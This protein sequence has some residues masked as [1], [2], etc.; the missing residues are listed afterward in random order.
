MNVR[1]RLTATAIYT[2]GLGFYAKTL[3]IIIP[4]VAVRLFVRMSRERNDDIV[5]HLVGALRDSAPMMPVAALYLIAASLVAI[6]HGATG[7]DLTSVLA[8]IKFTLIGLQYGMISALAGF[9]IVEETPD[10]ITFFGALV[11]DAALGCAVFVAL[12]R[13]SAALWLW[14]GL[15][16]TLIAGIGLIGL[17]R[18]AVYGPWSAAS[19]RY[20]LD[21]GM[22]IL[23]FASLG[24]GR[25]YAGRD[26]LTSLTTE[27]AFLAVSVPAMMLALWTGM[28]YPAVWDTAG[29]RQFMDAFRTSYTRE[30]QKAA[31]I[32]GERIMPALMTPSWMIDY[33]DSAI[34][35]GC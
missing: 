1:R 34:S 24:L 33:T 15:A 35:R 14:S 13:N 25:A 22:M 2:I 21:G 26:V 6:K 8:A 4:F 20:T 5:P 3:I 32:L 7:L 29:V 17:A 19:G 12:R 11:A 23:A 27:K 28:T 16:L 18:A 31:P 10:F 30:A 9:H